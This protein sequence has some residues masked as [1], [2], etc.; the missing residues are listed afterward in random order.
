MK[1]PVLCLMGAIAFVGA[2]LLVDDYIKLRDQVAYVEAETKRNRAVEKKKNG[3]P[4]VRASSAQ[5]IAD[6]KAKK[7]ESDPKETYWTVGGITSKA[8]DLLMLI[9]TFAV[10]CFTGGILFVEVRGK[11]RELRAYVHVTEHTMDDFTPG[12][13]PKPSLVIKN[14]GQTPAYRVIV[15][16]YAGILPTETSTFPIRHDLD[17]KRSMYVLGPGGERFKQQ[18]ELGK[19]NHEQ[20][21][22][23]MEDKT[24]RLFVWGRI[25]YEDAFKKP[26]WT[27][28]RYFWNTDI[29][30]RRGLILAADSQG[31]DADR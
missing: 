24:H 27:D 13:N 22:S 2:F 7:S 17:A 4:I 30:E 6:A 20:W 1:I 16:S 29:F 12:K 5:P 31:N 26:R 8:S 11:R 19:L 15:L 14:S 23:V 25:E 21:K 18:T 3:Q 28:F 10:V 9:L